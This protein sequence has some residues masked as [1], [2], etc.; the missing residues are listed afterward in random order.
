MGGMS[1][2]GQELGRG[3]EGV[4]DLE[5]QVATTRELVAFAKQRGIDL[6]P[7]CNDWAFLKDGRFMS[8]WR[9]RIRSIT[10]C[11]GQ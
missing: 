10:V 3:A 4:S 9:C 6:G 2:I 5:A 11:K 8:L 7:T 1:Q